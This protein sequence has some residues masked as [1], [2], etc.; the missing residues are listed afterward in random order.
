[1]IPARARDGSSQS[2]NALAF[3]E[4]SVAAGGTTNNVSR[5]NGSRNVTTIPNRFARLGALDQQAVMANTN[6]LQPLD[7][8]IMQCEARAKRR[9][10]DL[11][12]AVAAFSALL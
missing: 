7:W 12:A 2:G 4:R 3:A 10:L 1:L 8:C 6:E 9:L 5:G 11:T